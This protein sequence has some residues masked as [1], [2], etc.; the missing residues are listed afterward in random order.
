MNNLNMP[1]IDDSSRGKDDLERMPLAV[2]L[3]FSFDIK[4]TALALDAVYSDESVDA[5]LGAETWFFRKKERFIGARLG[6]NLPDLG[7]GIN[8]TA[9]FSLFIMKGFSFDYAFL[10]PLVTIRSIYGSHLF[11]MSYQ[12]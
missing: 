5:S 9:G 7:A 2:R 1:R 6:V 3:G 4:K 12:W 8:A 11:S 10:M